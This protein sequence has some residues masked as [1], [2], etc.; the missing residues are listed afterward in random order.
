MPIVQ[1]E[2]GMLIPVICDKTIDGRKMTTAIRLTWER[3]KAALAINRSVRLKRC[4][5]YSYAEVTFS[6]RNRGMSRRAPIGAR[7]HMPKTLRSK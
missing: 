3:I 5:R 1:M 7:M 6:C 2:N 4:S